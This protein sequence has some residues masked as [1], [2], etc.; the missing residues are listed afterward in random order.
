MGDSLGRLVRQWCND[1]E[2]TEMVDTDKDVDR[3][4]VV[5]WQLEK[6]DINNFKG[7]SRQRIWEN[8]SRSEGILSMWTRDVM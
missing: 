6:V 5:A 7:S 2:T 4:L 8:R 3:A 1:H